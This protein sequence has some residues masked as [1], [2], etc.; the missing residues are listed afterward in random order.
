[1][2]KEWRSKL[3]MFVFGNFCCLWLWKQLG[4][5]GKFQR[6]PW[7]VAGSFPCTNLLLKWLIAGQKNGPL[8][9]R[10]GG[11]EDDNFHLHI[12]NGIS[13]EPNHSNTTENTN[14]KDS[15]T[16]TESKPAIH[17]SGRWNHVDVVW[18]DWWTDQGLG[19]HHQLGEPV[20]RIFLVWPSHEQLAPSDWTYHGRESVGPNQR[21]VLLG[22]SFGQPM[23]LCPWPGH[24]HPGTA[25][26]ANC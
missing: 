20:Y 8:D 21:T 9:M 14:H 12:D 17:S 1:M 22:A 3:W 6:F 19:I 25:A 10:M 26:I 15:I 4:C 5:L 2:Y 24:R 7:H 11:N 23:D 18:F 16:S 13:H